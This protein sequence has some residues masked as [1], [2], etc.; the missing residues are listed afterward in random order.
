MFG[1]VY[2]VVVAGFMV[3]WFV[4]CDYVIDEMVVCEMVWF[5]NGVL[6]FGVIVVIYV[7][8]FVDD[9]VFLICCVMMIGFGVIVVD[10]CMLCFMCV[11]CLCIDVVVELLVNIIV[12]FIVGVLC[13]G[14]KFICG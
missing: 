2:V 9:G 8:V 7:V 4:S 11:V 3:G 10:E 6:I 13:V 5:C 14:V 12:L 1:G